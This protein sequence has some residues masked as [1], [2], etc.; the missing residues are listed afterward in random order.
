[1]SSRTSRIKWVDVF[2]GIMIFF[3]AF[4][5][6]SRTE[7]LK[8]YAYSF[9]VAAFFFISGYL[10]STSNLSFKQFAWKKFKSLMVPYYVFASISILIFSVLGSFASERLD[11]A[12]KSSNVLFNI[13]GMLWANTR[14]GYMK[15]NA[16]L[17]YIPC[18]FATMLVA[19]PLV[20]WISR[21][22]Q[23]RTLAYLLVAILLMAVSVLNYKVLHFYT[24]PFQFETLIFMFPFFSMGLLYRELSKN[25]NRSNPIIGAVLISI[26][27][28][29]AV[30]E[31]TVF[32]YISSQ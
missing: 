7:D 21:R 24:L 6:A 20:K 1:M 2:R 23:H 8:Q 5:H 22:H 31:N 29:L 27:Y 14:T 26:V 12:I 18:L 19:Y 28:I 32:N 3:I 10:F 13:V 25:C 30:Y 17:W 16:P 11:I 9:H 4:G 15:W